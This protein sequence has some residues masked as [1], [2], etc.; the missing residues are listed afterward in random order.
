[1]RQIN[2]DLKIIMSAG[3]DDPN[4][5]SNAVFY[6]AASTE[7][8]REALVSSMMNIYNQYDALYGLDGIDVDWEYPTNSDEIAAYTDYMSRINTALASADADGILTVAVPASQW[9]F[10]VF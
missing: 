8:K 1:M 9:A 7:A 4:L 6:A 3:T 10:S 2:T 5:G